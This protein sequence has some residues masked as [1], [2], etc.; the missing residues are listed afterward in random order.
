[1]IRRV[2]CA[3]GEWMVP[4]PSAFA[5]AKQHGK[6]PAGRVVSITRWCF[7]S[8]GAEQRSGHGSDLQIIG[9]SCLDRHLRRARLAQDAGG[10]RV[11]KAT[12]CL[13][14]SRATD[15]KCDACYR[16]DDSNLDRNFRFVKNH[17]ILKLNKLK[18][19]GTISDTFLILRNNSS[20][21]QDTLYTM[22]VV[23]QS[24]KA[25]FALESRLQT[26]I[27]GE[28]GVAR[29]VKQRIRRHTGRDKSKVPYSVEHD[30]VN[31][32]LTCGQVFHYGVPPREAGYCSLSTIE[33]L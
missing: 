5:G 18:L 9:G 1:M 11:L 24:G 28:Y 27:R 10:R 6:F 3:E 25:S 15:E 23:H 21:V 14:R 22:L 17:R 20:S 31:V 26:G 12:C 32:D 7:L 33:S 2:A 16:R 8:A 13:R 30:S 19:D 29:V 4:K